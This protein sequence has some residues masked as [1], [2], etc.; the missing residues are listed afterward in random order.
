FSAMRRIHMR[1]FILTHGHT[2][3]VGG[4]RLSTDVTDRHRLS[5]PPHGSSAMMVRPRLRSAMRRSPLLL[6]LALLLSMGALAHA[7][8]DFLYSR[9]SDY[10]DALRTQA[11]IPGLAAAIVGPTGVVWEAAFG[12]QDVERNV[13]TR[14]DTPFELDGTTE[15]VVASV[16]MWCSEHGLL[17]LSDRVA[18]YAPSSPDAGATLLQVMSHTTAGP[19]G[20]TFS[21]RPD[22][23]APLAAA[24]AKCT[25]PS[26][27]R[28]VGNLL[29]QLQ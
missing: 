14:T 5:R 17:S 29:N 20:L 27:R 11:G 6:T 8:D 22:R 12:Q 9:F 28:G 7:A 16:A 21:Y 19:G 23:L 2:G 15:A 1:T 26:L 10:L 13:A 4:A 3:F 18:A 25:D 24:V